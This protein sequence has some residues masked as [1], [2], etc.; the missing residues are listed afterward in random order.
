M[1]LTV[2]IHVAISR[3]PYE[4]IYVKFGVLGFFHHVLLKYGHENAEILMQKQQF[5]TSHFG[6]LYGYTLYGS[7]IWI[8]TTGSQ[9][10]YSKSSKAGYQIHSSKLC[11]L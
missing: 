5:V 11:T 10:C 7:E 9:Y 6:T 1:G 2:G 3:G 4:P 8:S